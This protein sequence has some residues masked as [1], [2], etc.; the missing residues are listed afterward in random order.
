MKHEILVH[1]IRPNGELEI[2]DVTKNFANMTD[3]FFAKIT[4]AT[5]KAGKGD[6]IRAEEII[7]RSNLLQ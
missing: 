1:I 4:E 6:V 5:K 3:M 7:P 2:V